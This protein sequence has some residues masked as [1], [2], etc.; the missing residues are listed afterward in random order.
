MGYLTPYQGIFEP[1]GYIGILCVGETFNSMNNDD[2]VKL[3]ST[4][5]TW[6]GKME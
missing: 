2:T 1:F 3:L 4:I 5:T 6:I